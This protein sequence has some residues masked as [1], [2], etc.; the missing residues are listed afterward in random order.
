MTR[1]GFEAV[2]DA[3]GNA[4][5]PEHV[6]LLDADG[7]ERP[8]TLISA[9]GP[10]G[11]SRGLAILA[12]ARQVTAAGRRP[13]LCATDLDLP[14]I[15]DGPLAIEL[16]PRRVDVPVL[17]HA[18][19]AAYLERRWEIILAKWQITEEISLGQD[20][21]SFLADQSSPDRSGR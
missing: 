17:D 15:V 2:E 12:V 19:Y 1:T 5:D 9:L 14:S 3:S 6:A 13:I 10:A 4:P 20:F 8:R 11:R 16:L 21:A 7:V 18:E